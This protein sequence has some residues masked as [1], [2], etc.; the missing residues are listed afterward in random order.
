MTSPCRRRGTLIVANEEDGA[1]NNDTSA[2]ILHKH[3]GEKANYGKIGRQ[4]YDDMCDS[5]QVNSR[6]ARTISVTYQPSGLNTLFVAPAA[7]FGNVHA[8]SVI[9]MDVADG[10]LGVSVCIDNKLH[11]WES[12]R[13]EVRRRLEGHLF[14]AYSC[15]LFPSGTVVLSAGGDMQLRI[16]DV[17]SGACPVILKGHTAAILDT[18]IVERGKNIIS[19]SRDGTA[20]LWN[21]GTAECISVVFSCDSPINNCDITHVGHEVPLPNPQ[22][23]SGSIRIGTKYQIIILLCR[24]GLINL[25]TCGAKEFVISS[26]IGSVKELCIGGVQDDISLGSI[27]FGGT[28]A[29]VHSRTTSP[30]VHSS[31]SDVQCLFRFNQGFLVGRRDGLCQ[32]YTLDGTNPCQL[33]GSDCDPIYSCASD[34][35]HVYTASRDGK[36]R[37]YNIRDMQL[38]A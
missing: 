37:K 16:W 19:V 35:T 33:T 6:T 22:D 18:A 36:I 26:F 4:G 29:D 38:M 28:L 11:V 1:C 20:R 21:C 24:C 5:F 3:L 34:N 30:F 12:S 7:V 31:A 9:S 2:W 32:Y 10:G 25:I 8:K 23:Q 27:S 14:D 15:R 13:G 17:A